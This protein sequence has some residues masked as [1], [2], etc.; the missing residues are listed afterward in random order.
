MPIKSG[1]GPPEFVS[2]ERDRVVLRFASA[3]ARKLDLD[4]NIEIVVSFS[5]DELN[6]VRS[7]AECPTGFGS[8]T[9]EP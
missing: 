1:N 2:V 4:E 8:P 5:D 3:L 9:G 6:R 7:L